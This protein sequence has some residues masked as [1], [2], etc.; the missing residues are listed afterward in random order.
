MRSTSTLS[1]WRY[2]VEGCTTIRSSIYFELISSRMDVEAT[3]PS[4]IISLWKL[5]QILVFFL[6]THSNLFVELYVMYACIY[7]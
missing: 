5:F 4:F 6:F 1:S 2:N 7:R 3:H